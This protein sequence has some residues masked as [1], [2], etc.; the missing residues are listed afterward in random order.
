MFNW[1]ALIWGALAGFVVITI[2]SVI[3]Y[4]KENA[5]ENFELSADGVK[6]V[7]EYRTYIVNQWINLLS[8]WFDIDAKE[9]QTKLTL[10][11]ANKNGLYFYHQNLEVYAMFDWT[12]DTMDVKTTVWVDP[13]G[14]K[15]H[16]KRFGIVNGGLEAEKL[17]EFVK[18]AKKE[19]YG[20]Y[21]LSPE[22]VN[23]ITKELAKQDDAFNNEEEANC[24]LFNYMADLMIL[25]RDEKF[26]NDKKFMN[27][28]MGLVYHFW[29]T[30][31][32]LFMKYLT[33]E[34]DP[35]DDEDNE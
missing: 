33:E 26:R 19:H 4:F 10:I 22:E 13:E 6:Q 12:R 29:Q 31:G 8:F 11:D 20:L 32:D 2:C 7:A 3:R 21:E 9:T 24:H 5:E 30:K 27:I 23:D 1:E 35:S 25:A 18:I 16:S 17:L 34:D 15:V 28:Y 14:Y